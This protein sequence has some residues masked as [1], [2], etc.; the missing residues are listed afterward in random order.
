MNGTLCAIVV[1]VGEYTGYGI[2]G[3]NKPC[4]H[5]TK[6]LTNTFSLMAIIITFK[7]LQL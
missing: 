5:L 4:S 2:A 6:Q 1:V 3:L 7:H